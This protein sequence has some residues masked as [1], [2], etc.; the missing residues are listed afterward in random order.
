MNKSIQNGIGNVFGWV[1]GLAFMWFMIW[2]TGRMVDWTYTYVWVNY[3]IVIALWISLYGWWYNTRRKND[4]ART[5]IV[6]NKLIDD[7]R[8]THPEVEDYLTNV[9]GVERE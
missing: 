4:Y 6:L 2:I 1:L 9:L 3:T 8:D 5:S 7:L